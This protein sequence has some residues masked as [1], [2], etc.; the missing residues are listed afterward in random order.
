MYLFN[1]ISSFTPEYKEVY[2][3][4]VSLLYTFEYRTRSAVLLSLINEVVAFCAVD[5][6]F[7]ETMGDG[8]NL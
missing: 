5:I 6:V 8:V 1:I 2:T 3:I 7:E 4:L